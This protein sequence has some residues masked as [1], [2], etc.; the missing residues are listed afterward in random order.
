MSTFFRKVVA[1]LWFLALLVLLGIFVGG[2]ATTPNKNIGVPSNC[3]LYA[4]PYTNQSFTSFQ[5]GFNL[6]GN[7]ACQSAVIE[8]VVA[9]MTAIFMAV[10]TVIYVGYVH[11]AF[12]ARCIAYMSS[13]LSV[14]VIVISAIASIGFYQTCANT[15]FCSA[16]APDFSTQYSLVQVAV[17]CGWFASALLFIHAMQAWYTVGVHSLDHLRETTAHQKRGWSNAPWRRERD[18]ESLPEVPS[19]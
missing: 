13:I 8:G 7:S 11:T 4:S 16:G 2:L 3:L 14:F 15:T 6:P 12:I 1:G 18:N 5:N 19:I 9:M 17:L 10:I